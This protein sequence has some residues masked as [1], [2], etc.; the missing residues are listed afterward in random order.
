MY[1]CFRERDRFL[2]EFSVISNASFTTLNKFTLSHTIIRHRS[3]QSAFHAAELGGSPHQPK[4]V[5][6]L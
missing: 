3:V 4:Y 5:S 6:T 2:T 1:F